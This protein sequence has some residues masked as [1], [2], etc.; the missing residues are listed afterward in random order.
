M[1]RTKDIYYDHKHPEELQFY[2]DEGAV[3]KLYSKELT[4]LE[5]HD[6]YYRWLTDPLK[7]E[8]PGKSYNQLL[9]RLSNL[10]FFWTV[11]NDDNRGVDGLKLREDFIEH[12]NLG[13]YEMAILAKENCSVLEMLVALAI[14]INDICDGE[15][16][17]PKWFWN[18]LKNIGLDNCSDE[19]YQT[20]NG[21]VRVERYM[22]NMLSRSY[23]RDGS[24]GLFPLQHPHADQR[25]VELWYQMQAYLNER[26]QLDSGTS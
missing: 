2:E 10:P 18:M 25:G 5:I 13:F 8:M 22:N 9:K 1:S 16:G 17:A 12:M 23:G 15:E 21:H 6:Q 24:G 7:A 11:P 4:P 26:Y 3:S 20:L 19:R 14:R